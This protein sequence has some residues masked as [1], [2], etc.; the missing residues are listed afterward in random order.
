MNLICKHCSAF[1]WKDEHPGMCCSNGKVKLETLQHPPEPLDHL[2]QGVSQTSKRFLANIRKYN[3]CFQMTSFGASKEIREQGF[4]PT[5]KVQG[6]IYHRAGSLL[7]A[8]GEPQFLHIYFMGDQAR[9]VQQRCA[10]I[11]DLQQNVVLE[12]QELLHANNAYL[13]IFKTALERMP[14]DEY[15]VVIRADKAPRHEHQR[16]FNVPTFDEVAIVMVGNEFDRR[17]IVLQKRNNLLQRVAETHRSYDALQYPLM[18]W[19]GEDGYSFGIPQ[20]NPDTGNNVLGK[21]VTAMDFYAYRIMIRSGEDNHLLKFRQLFHQFIVD[22]YAK[23]ESERLLYIR[24]NQKKLRV[25]DYIHLRDAIAND[26]NPN[27]LGKMV[28]L[29]AT[30]TGSP[31]HMHEYTQDAMTYVRNYGRPDLFITFTCNPLW[32][33]IQAHLLPGQSAVDRHDLV[34]RVF[35]RKLSKLMGVITKSHVYGE[36]RCWMYSIEWQKRGLPHAHILIWLMKKLRPNQIDNVISAEIPNSTQDNFLFEIV[37][38]N[39]LHGPCGNLNRNSACM[40]DGKCSK[41]YPRNLIQE[42]KTGEDGY[43]VYRRRKP[44]D[45]GFTAKIKMKVGSTYQEIE[46]DNRWVVPYTPILTKMFQAHINVE[47]CQ[48]VKA[49]KYIC[50]YV[51]KGSDQ[52]VFGLEGNQ[53]NPDEVQKFLMGR[54]ISSNEAVWRILNFQ[55]HERYPTVVHLSVH[56]ENGQRVYFNQENI[57]H[58]ILEPPRTT[59]TAFFQLC[60]Q[61]DFAKTILYCVVPRYYTWNASQKLFKRRKQGADVEYH[62]GI[63]SSDA[64]GRVYTVHPSNAECFFLR[65]LLHVVRGPTSYTDLKTVDGHVCATFR[66][67]CQMQG[68]LEND[69]HWVL[70]M[71]EACTSQSPTRLRHLFSI[72]LTTCAVSNPLALWDTFK[73]YLSEDIMLQTKRENQTLLIEFSNEI[74]KRCL[75]LLE[76]LCVSM[77][78]RNLDQFGLPTPRRNENNLQNSEILREQNYNTNELM[79]YVSENQPRL[80]EDQRAAYI[81]ILELV[82]SKKGGIIFLDAP[83]GTG[84]TF[85]INLLLAT[86][87]RDKGIA[88]AVASSG[89]AS[90]LL[91]GGRTA[92]SAFKLPLNMNHSENVTC[93]ISKGSGKA[94]VLEQCSLIVWDECT[95]SHKRALEALNN[96]LQDLKGNTKL[97]GGTVVVLAGDFRQTLPVIPRSTPS[98]ELNA[99][100]KAST[101]WKQVKKMTLTTNMR[102]HLHGDNA[103]G[104]FSHQLL[105]LGDGKWQVDPAS[106]TVSFP[107]NFC[108]VAKSLEELK[109]AVFPNIQDQFKNPEWLCEKA[110]LAPKNSSVNSINSQIHNFLPGISKNYKSIDTVT[111]PAQAVYYPTE[112]LNSLDPPGMPSHNLELKIGAPIILLRNLDPPKLCNGTRLSIKHLLPHVIEATILTGCAKGEDVFIPRIPLIPTDMPFDFKRLQFPIRLAFAMSINKAQGQSLKVAGIVLE[113]ACFAHGQLYVACSRVGSPTNLFNFAPEGKTKNIVYRQALI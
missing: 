32:Q 8:E 110:I 106:G 107:S 22:M 73:T 6:Q 33:E 15:K 1:K 61:D 79:T 29:P 81:H 37:V 64:L 68:L 76:D 87:R 31:R 50:K 67:A 112:F 98:D 17:D 43:P 23:I 85:V 92:H 63:K 14:T 27:D 90:T 46:M 10:N 3:S 78:G 99:F 89:I 83:G 108:T 40:V 72:L 53:E 109:L 94:K 48:S 65:M 34:A 35:K 102:V 96:T 36:T 47:S 111:D 12:L 2:L 54:Y 26:A 59:L 51:N 62:P 113:E 70:T 80:V 103:A 74:Y 93:N 55:I 101:L 45:G 7:P 77:S 100:L 4:M 91:A 21:K 82:T 13:H 24:L 49:I 41:K 39:M 38:K 88:L 95:M 52:A 105:Q 25:E 86:I 5:F 16:R 69:H 57:Y 44:G 75:M 66:E 104:Y 11:P 56:L 97:M 9:E 58:Q 84:K 60:Q 30:F 71:E 28:I 18:F 19:Q 42:T 20:T